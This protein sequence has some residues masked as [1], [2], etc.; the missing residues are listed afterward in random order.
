MKKF[1]N[2]LAIAIAFLFSA[3]S[4]NAQTPAAGSI[5][6]TP[7]VGVNFT[8]LQGDNNQTLDSKVGINVG[9]EAL[10]MCND[11]IGISVGAMYSQQG[12][13]VKDTTLGI[14]Y[15]NVPVMLNGYVAKGLALK[16][17]VQAGFKVNDKATANGVSV[18]LDTMSKLVG[19]DATVKSFDVS[20]PVGISYEFK[21]I[22]LDARANLG[23]ISVFKDKNLS[24]R[25]STVQLSLGYRF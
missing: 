6:V 23:V 19:G 4:V 25:N 17:G 11:N 24:A 13:K 2:N 22:V 9:A 15:V 5:T 16:A 1:V 3:T 14:D 20:V 12:C 21:N 8:N 7:M 18:D 10:Y